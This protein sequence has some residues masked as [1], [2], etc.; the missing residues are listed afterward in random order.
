MRSATAA[1]LP[2]GRVFGPQIEIASNGRAGH[3]YGEALGLGWFGADTSRV[4]PWHEDCWN[5]FEVLL[6]GQRIRIWVNEEPVAD[7]TDDQSGLSE[8]VICF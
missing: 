6:K 5:R 4:A 7:L 3:V 1:G 2:R 8:G